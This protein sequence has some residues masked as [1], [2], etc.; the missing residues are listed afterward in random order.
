MSQLWWRAGSEAA[1]AGCQAGR[2]SGIHTTRLEAGWLR[3]SFLPWSS[4]VQSH[5]PPNVRTSLLNLESLEQIVS[6]W[7]GHHSD[8]ELRKVARATDAPTWT[9]R[10]AAGVHPRRA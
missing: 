2:I 1:S 5:S 9:E 3:K 6:D 8:E 7:C 4:C 10:Q